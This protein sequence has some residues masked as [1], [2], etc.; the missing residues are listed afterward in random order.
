MKR[1]LIT[2][3]AMCFLMA[4]PSPEGNWKLSGLAVDYLHISREEAVVTLDDAYGFG[5]SVPVQV[6]PSGVLF[7]RLTNGPFTLP[8]IDAAGLNLNVNLYPDGTGAVAEG[9]FYP[10]IDLIPGTCITQGQ[11]FPVTDSFVYEVGAESTFPGTNILGIPG[12][13]ANAGAQGWGF[14]V[15]QSSTFDAFQANA[16]PERVPADVP[17][18]ALSD[19]TVLGVSCGVAGAMN[20]MEGEALAEF[21]GQCL[22]ADYATAATYFGGAGWL[23]GS[24]NGG[25]FNLDMGNSQMGQDLNVDFLLE[26]DG[27]DGDQTGS[28]LGDDPDVDENGDGSLIDRIFGLPYIPATYING[29]N[30]LCDISGG[31]LA[32]GP[33]L[34]AYPLAGDVVGAL[35]GAE[36]VAALVTGSCLGGVAGQVNDLCESAATATTCADTDN[37][38]TDS[39]G[40][41]CE[42]NGSSC[43][44]GYYDDDDFNEMEMCCA[45]GGGAEASDGP[46]NA[47]TGLCYEASQSADFA[48][49]CAYYGGAGALT[50]TCLQLGFDT[51][52]CAAAAEQAMPAVNAYCIYATGYDCATAGIDECAVLT[53]PDF[54]MGLCGTLAGALTTSSNCADWT[55]SFDTDWLDAQFATQAGMTCSEYGAGYVDMCVEAVDYANDMYLVDPALGTTWGMFLTYN[56]ASV[57]QYQAAGYDLAT[58][59]AAFPE[60]FVNDS[61]WDFDP[62]CYADGDGSDCSGRLVMNFEPLC[63]NELEARQIVAEFVNLDDLCE[64]QGDVNGDGD[65]NVVDVV[66]VVGHVLGDPLGGYGFCQADLNGDGVVNVVDVVMLVNSILSSRELQQE[67]TTAEI[68]LSNGHIDIISDG[69][70]GGIDMIVEFSGEL[71]LDISDRYISD[72]VINDDRTARIIIASNEDIN[73]ALDVVSGNITAIKEATLVTGEN[74]DY[75]ELNN[76]TISEP[77]AFSIGN[78]YPNPFNPSTNLSLELTATADISVKVFNIMGQLVD[79]I[80]EGTYSPNTYSWTWNADNLASGVY[81]V[82]T[83]V[84]DFVDNQKVMLLK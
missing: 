62:A 82:R 71:S 36:G 21:V 25:W 3:S 47:V 67:A 83:Q 24:G 79:V 42:M 18:V 5:I 84:G 70:I 10:D 74:G 34:G 4:D 66:R 29:E 60:L 45:C 39:W 20:G 16:V 8:I 12:I 37:G 27:I 15:D 23:H 80:A 51:E 13:N 31:A 11:T 32:G 41:S 78:A 38:A 81:L 50:A 33:G 53:N 59:Q 7:Q 30:P 58:I 63:I 61:G 73:E 72:Y 68:S 26:W 76:V 64:A 2:L 6:I 52:T 55:A 49:A 48:G 22:A 44:G 46:V 77:S 1:L 17:Y 9:S 14:G 69:Y 57:Q 75:S 40:Y 43:Y 35:G 19:G 56:A 28:G 65:T 54:S